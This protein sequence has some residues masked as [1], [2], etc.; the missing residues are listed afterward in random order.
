MFL[1]GTA[2]AANPVTK[3]NNASKEVSTLLKQELLP[4]SSEVGLTS[5]DRFSSNLILGLL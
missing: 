1:T 5:F 3:T 4:D 2:F